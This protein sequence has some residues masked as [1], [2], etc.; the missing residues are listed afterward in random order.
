MVEAFD[1][2]YRWLGIPPSAQ[3]PNHYCLLGLVDFEPDPDVIA[4]AADR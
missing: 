3:P 2:Y 1:P 4:S